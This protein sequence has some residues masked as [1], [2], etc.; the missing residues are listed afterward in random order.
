[1]TEGQPVRLIRDCDAPGDVLVQINP[2]QTASLGSV[3]PTKGAYCFVVD[4]SGS[5]TAAADVKND[6]GD[7]V[8]LGFCLL[9][10]AKH[11]TN[12]FI[13]SLEDDDYVALV[14]YGSAAVVHMSWTKC[15]EAGR[16]TAIERVNAMNIA[17]ST[18]L[19]AGVTTGFETFQ[20][21]P[22]PTEEL[23]CYSQHLIVATDGQPDQRMD[24]SPLVNQKQEELVAKRESPAARVNVTTIGLGNQLDSEL[25][26]GMADTFLH[27][28]DP[29]AVGPF[30][31]NLLANARSSAIYEGVVANRA[32]LVVRPAS[33]L[34]APKSTSRRLT[35]GLARWLSGGLQ[36]RNSAEASPNSRSRSNSSDSVNN[37]GGP[38]NSELVSI[39]WPKGEVKGDAVR[40]AIGLVGYDQP[41]HFLLRAKAGTSL[42]VELEVNGKV[43]ACGALS[44]A[45]EPCTEAESLVIKAERLRLQAVDALYAAVALPDN[46][47]PEAPINACLESIA[48]SP[49]SDLPAVAALATTLRDEVIVGMSDAQARLAWGKHYCRT[50]AGMLR[51]ERRSNFRDACLQH[52]GRDAQG[53]DALFG[54]Q[55]DAAELAFA[56]LA[57]P[58]PSLAARRDVAYTPPPALPAEY[59]RGGGCFAPWATVEVEGKGATR[60]DGVAKGDR[61]R[62]A[63][64]GVAAVRCVVLT[65]CLGGRAVL[66]TLPI[67]R[68][69]LTE[70]HPVLCEDGRF[71]FPLLLGETRL[72][73]CAH[74]YNLVLDRCHVPLVNGV[75]CVSLGHGIEADPVAYHAY[76]GGTVL[77]DLAALPG[78]AEGR[79]L[80]EHRTLPADVGPSTP[81]QIPP[82]LQ[83]VCVAAC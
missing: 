15:D 27:M 59:M 41:R 37:S 40:L 31:V 16:T 69:E 26:R 23:P 14:T 8:S 75:G 64:G 24:Y 60:L 50:L 2:P 58:T 63:D 51:S 73:A 9:D 66:V 55:S 47:A 53:R 61:V 35:G 76:W 70:W 62:T 10:I 42:T 5:M 11:A 57:P 7:K 22:V 54:E 6:D 78:W 17:G 25:L 20:E 80:L 43:V 32:T 56:T 4:V 71:R 33:A 3:K 52:F 81:A 34:G 18:N 45:T 12:T 68:L 28:P 19:V 46:Q 29:G 48:A 79:V 36:R 21:L 83:P 67:S 1:M 38:D 13:S 39:G 74:V 30:M 65:P 44:A 72:R 77:A 82:P 49:A